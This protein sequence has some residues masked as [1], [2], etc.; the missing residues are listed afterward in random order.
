MAQSRRGGSNGRQVMKVTTTTKPAVK[1]LNPKNHSD[2]NR[3]GRHMMH[4]PHIKG[5]TLKF[6]HMDIPATDSRGKVTRSINL[7]GGH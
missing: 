4:K 3:D 2:L 7:K 6:G 5:G 1:K